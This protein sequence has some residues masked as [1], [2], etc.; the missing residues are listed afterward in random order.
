VIALHQAGA[1]NA[2]ATSGTALTPEQ[3]R[4]IQRVAPRVALTYDGDEAGQGAMMRSLGVLLGEG[5]EVMVVTCRAATTPTRWCAAAASRPGTPSAAACDPIAFIQRHGLRRGGPGD[6]AN[7]RCGRWWSCGRDSDPIRVRLLLERASQ[8]FGLSE[9][10]LAH[11]AALRRSGQRAEA[12]IAA[13]LRQRTG[14]GSHLERELLRALLFAREGLESARR[15]LSPEDFEEPACA[16]LA[17][18]LWAAGRADRRTRRR[19]R[20]PAS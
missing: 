3:A 14:G 15:D 11:A 20:S 16:A 9:S 4:L 19:P 2:V 8:I 17:R 1:R 7:W 6:P 12:P 5:V 13:A 10:V 18:H